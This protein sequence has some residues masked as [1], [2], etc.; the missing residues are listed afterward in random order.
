MAFYR[1][2]STQLTMN[3]PFQSTNFMVYEA[4]R[5]QLNPD[6]HYN[7][8]VCLYSGQLLHSVLVCPDI[9][10]CCACIFEIRTTY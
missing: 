10:V 7:P 5:K 8:Q 2:Y 3:I 6:G 4:V 1:S 9:D